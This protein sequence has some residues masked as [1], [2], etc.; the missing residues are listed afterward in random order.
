MRLIDGTLIGCANSPGCA[1]HSHFAGH[2][3]YGYCPS[4][5]EFVWGMRLVLVADPKGVPVGYDLGGPNTGEERDSALWLAAAH[6]GSLLF[7]DGGL[8]GRELDA[9]LESGGR[10]H[11][12]VA[13]WPWL[14]ILAMGTRGLRRAG[15]RRSN[16]GFGGG[17]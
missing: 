10:S 7:A 17:V 4:K 8:W 6:P 12:V 5:S 9:S 1:S 3:S 16:P 13:G 14:E 15:R 2:A 11:R